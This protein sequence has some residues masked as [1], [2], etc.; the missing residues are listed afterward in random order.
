[1]C[2]PNFTK[3][4]QIL[5]ARQVRSNTHMPVNR[6]SCSYYPLPRQSRLPRIWRTQRVKNRSGCPKAL[7][8]SRFLNVRGLLFFVRHPN[9]SRLG[10]SMNLGRSGRIPRK[11]GAAKL[12]RGVAA[13]FQGHIEIDL[14]TCLSGCLHQ[15]WQDQYKHGVHG[16]VH[17]YTTR[18]I[19]PP[20]V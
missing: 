20:Q 14:V 19:P 12:L 5:Y 4:R 17:Q 6:T 18:Q 15:G 11:L 8:H 10:S 1:M 13:T 2:A 3:F 7:R 9:C 16:R